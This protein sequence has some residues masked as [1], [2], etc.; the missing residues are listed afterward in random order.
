MEVSEVSAIPELVY[1]VRAEH[2]ARQLAPGQRH[3]DA[4]AA[5]DVARVAQDARAVVVPADGVPA[6]ENGQRT[7][8][9]EAPRAVAK[10]RVGAMPP[11]SGRR[12]ARS[13]VWI[14]ASRRPASNASSC[15]RSP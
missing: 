14:A 11:A 4:V 1:V 8:G 12:R 3:A 5:V 10:L 2:L 9:L 6:A 13:R 7:Q 15:R